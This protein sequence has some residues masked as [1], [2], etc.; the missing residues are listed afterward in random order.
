MQV[1]IGLWVLGVLLL[2]AAFYFAVTQVEVAGR[3]ELVQCGNALGS[4]PGMA[5]GETVATCE[6]A[7]IDR[8][9]LSGFLLIGA[10]MS[11]LIGFAAVPREDD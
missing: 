9:V 1:K 4:S 10:A 5:T 6:D 3:T 2:I 7:V 11:T 8:R